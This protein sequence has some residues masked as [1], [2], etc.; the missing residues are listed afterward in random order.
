MLAGVVVERIERR[1]HSENSMVQSSHVS[2][3]TVI[4]RKDDGT[5]GTLH[6]GQ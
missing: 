4:Y 6:T 1:C 5:T 2:G 3:Y